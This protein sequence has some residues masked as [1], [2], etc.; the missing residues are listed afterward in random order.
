LRALQEGTIRRLGDTKD[1]QVD[2]RV[3][4]ATVR[5]LSTEVKE[6]RFREDLYYRLNVLQISL[7]PLRDRAGDLPLLVEH[8]LEKYNARLGTRTRGVSPDAL[9]VML[10]YSWPGNVRELEN[11][12]ERA[13][14]LAEG[15]LLTVDDLPDRLRAREDPVALTLAGGELSIKHTT[16]VIE[17]T[18]IRRALE[19]TGGNRTAA[20]RLLEISHRALLYKIKDYGIA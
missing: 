20:A 11:M 13:V 16:R 14:V 9:K 2:V 12:I 4:A 18:L 3:I 17:E 15:D 7:P 10:R 1:T 6:G 19:R 8:F 5:D